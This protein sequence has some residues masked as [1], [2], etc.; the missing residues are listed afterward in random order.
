M[1]YFIV[2]KT[3][4]TNDRKLESCMAQFSF[5]IVFLAFGAF[6]ISDFIRVT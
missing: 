2:R 5:P 1:P 3:P 4:K 6:M